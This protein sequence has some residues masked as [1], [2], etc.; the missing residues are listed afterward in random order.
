MLAEAFR[1]VAH[2]MLSWCS[3]CP[4]GSCTNCTFACAGAVDG[5][6]A[7]QGITRDG[8]LATAA[9]TAP[10]AKN[11]LHHAPNPAS[12]TSSLTPA[13]AAMVGLSGVDGTR[14]PRFPPAGDTHTTHTNT[15]ATQASGGAGASAVS[16]PNLFRM[17]SGHVLS[18][19]AATDPDKVFLAQGAGDGTGNSDLGVPLDTNSDLS[20]FDNEKLANELENGVAN[21]FDAPDSPPRVDDN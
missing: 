11:P 15:N 18:A 4:V 9:T 20:W 12:L 8:N 1:V 19:G 13:V 7:S 16:T 14:G 3:Q 10:S 6:A 2:T 21:I 17:T 5:A